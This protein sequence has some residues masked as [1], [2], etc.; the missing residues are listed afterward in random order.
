MSRGRVVAPSLSRRC[1]SAGARSPSLSVKTVLTSATYCI[2]SR[3]DTETNNS[4]AIVLITIDR[5]TS[6]VVFTRSD[7]QEARFP[8][9]S[10][11]FDNTSNLA[12]IDVPSSFDALLVTT[13]AGDQIL[14]EM[15]TDEVDRL[16]QRLVIYLDQNQWSALSN[17]IH[18]RQTSPEVRTA[19]QKLQEWVEQ[20][21]IILP[22]SAGHYYETSKWFDNRRR[23]QLGLTILQYSRGWLM[24]DPLK[25]RRNEL[26]DHMHQHK[27]TGY[28]RS[29]PVFTLAANALYSKVRDSSL[30]PYTDSPEISLSRQF[31]A[32]REAV[33]SID[34]MLDA[35]PIEPGP[36]TGWA[37]VNQLFSDAIDGE[38]LDSQQ[39]RKIIDAFLLK[40]LTAEMA[41]EAATAGL[42]T[43]QFEKWLKRYALKGY[44]GLHSIGLF[45]EMMLNRHLN[46]G[47]KWTSNDCTDMVYLSCAAGYA[48]V[49]VCERHMRDPLQHGLRRKGLKAHTFRRLPEA[50]AAIERML[51]ESAA[52]QAETA[53]TS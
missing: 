16:A 2:I 15:P 37:A 40:D 4:P 49:V 34:T 39:K 21:R 3:V 19:A 13:L 27:G 11:M 22:A 38:N 14:F 45:R 36:D 46:K 8:L 9:N 31:E 18:G 23:Y 33:A 17:A 26:H 53:E 30:P 35:E 7:M 51:K 10:P 1:H 25:V 44:E 48:D 32:L 12:R 29:E 20:R 50:V 47:T 42:T 41:H 52:P 6:S 28:S 24:R 43:E 5:T